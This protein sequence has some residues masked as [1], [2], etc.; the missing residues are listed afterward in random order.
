M[1]RSSL[2]RELKNFTSRP[3]HSFKLN[4]KR[5]TTCITKRSPFSTALTFPEFNHTLVPTS[6]S[7]KVQKSRSIETSSFSANLT[8]FNDAFSETNQARLI[9]QLG[10]MKPSKS[11]LASCSEEAAVFVPFCLVNSVPSVLL[12]LRS[13]RLNSH[14]GEVS[15]PGGKRDPEDKSLVETAIR[16]M[17]EEL[18]IEKSHVQVWASMPPVPEKQGRAGKTAVTAV[19]GYVG[20][21]DVNS[22]ELNQEE[23][24]SV[25]TLS[26]EHLC[27]PVNSRYTTF[28]R[29]VLI[30]LPV[31]VNGPHKVWG[32][33]ATI[34]EQVLLALIPEMYKKQLFRFGNKT[35]PLL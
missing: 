5:C 24:E 7:S 27:D 21:I 10:R 20:E 11:F 15:F 34:L 26:L 31:F 16:E 8:N 4:S 13:S 17:E 29:Q 18:G 3:V 28:K 19:V 30:R 22:L 12:T 14:R 1:P 25:F 33:T 23:V 9:K 2:A 32:L 6:F 35:F